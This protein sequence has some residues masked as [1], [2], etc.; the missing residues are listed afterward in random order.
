M[1]YLPRWKTV[2]AQA[3][4]S[5]V[6]GPKTAR[7]IAD[8]CCVGDADIEAILRRTIE[9]KTILVTRGKR[10]RIYRL[11]PRVRPDLVREVLGPADDDE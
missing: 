4:L 5:I 2:A 7:Q 3:L 1:I 6:D 9:R 11:N 10:P 8:A